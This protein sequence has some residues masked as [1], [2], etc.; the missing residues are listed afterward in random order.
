MTDKIIVNNK[1]MTDQIMF[2]LNKFDNE[3]TKEE[4]ANIKE[5]VI[6]YNQESNDIFLSNLPKFDNIESLTIRNEYIFNSDYNYF[7]ELKN[8]N[9]LVFDNCEFED[10]DLIASLKLKSLSLINCHIYNY[11]FISL[12]FDIE[13]LTIINGKISNSKINN[14]NN[15]HYL[16]LS[17]SHI[18]D[19]E[20]T[21][22]NINLMELHVDN[23]N[24]IDLSFIKNLPNLKII[25]IDKKQ[26]NNNKNL[27]DNSKHIKTNIVSNVG[28]DNYEI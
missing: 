15:L 25:S 2:K 18:L 28:V 9:T 16:Q 26:Y 23:T 1:N 21:I 27:I 13:E 12:L 11:S 5:L 14:L 17:H 24:I 4:L 10:A 20:K 8:I 7:L 6:D 22:K 3:F 19:S